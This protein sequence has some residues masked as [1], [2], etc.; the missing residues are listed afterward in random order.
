MWDA[1]V[2]R[3]RMEHHLVW[4]SHHGPIPDGYQV[5]HKNECKTDNRVENL[6]LLTPLE[7]KRLHSGCRRD[8]NGVWIKPCRKC[9]RELPVEA[10]YYKRADALLSNRETRLR[11]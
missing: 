3:S 9:G 2:K 10:G 5:H 8:E 7:H 11:V 1:S 6:E 4:E